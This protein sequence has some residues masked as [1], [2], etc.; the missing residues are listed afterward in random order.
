MQAQSP[1]ITG[2]AHIALRVA[3]LERS[4]AFFR[5]LGFEEAFTLG[6]GGKAAEVFVKINDRQFIELYPRTSEFETLG[7]MHVCYEADSANGLHDLAGERGLNPSPVVKGAAGNLLFSVKD[8]EGRLVEITQYLPGSL[9]FN[10]RGKHLGNERVADEMVGIR[11]P[12][13]EAAMEN[14]YAAGLGFK[15]RN[16]KRSR[17]MRLSGNAQEWIEISAAEAGLPVQFRLKTA[18][19]GA[20]AS[21]LELRGLAVK[22]QRNAVVV[23][24]PDGN[25]FV[26]AGGGSALVLQ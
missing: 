15:P 10:D 1:Q 2:I 20:A 4:R 24:D 9:H 21:R 8:T 14:F 18:D 16:G 13:A 6:D 26:F 25:V 23:D 5:L 3:D 7:W 12:G 11:M 17:Q 22:R 19:A